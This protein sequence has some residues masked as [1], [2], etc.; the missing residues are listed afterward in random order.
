[1]AVVAGLD[2]KRPGFSPGL[3]DTFYTKNS[4]KFLSDAAQLHRQHTHNL[5][6]AAIPA[7][8]QYW[9]QLEAGRVVSCSTA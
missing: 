9:G 5:A 3:S 6:E 8:H 2:T 7:S 1:M 4:F